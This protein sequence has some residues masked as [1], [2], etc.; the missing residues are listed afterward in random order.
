MFAQ[1][2]F[3]NLQKARH[4]AFMF[5]GAHDEITLFDGSD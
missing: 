4:K 2:N 3:V 5:L 1:K